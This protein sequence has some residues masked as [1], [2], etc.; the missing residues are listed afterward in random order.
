MFPRSL[1]GSVLQDASFRNQYA[2]KVDAKL[3]FG[4]VQLQRSVLFGAIRKLYDGSATTE[5]TTVDG[6]TATLTLR[7]NPDDNGVDIAID[8]KTIQVPSFWFLSSDSELRR[9]EFAREASTIDF[10]EKSLAF[11]STRFDG[12]ALSDD[13]VLD[14][15]E[16]LKTTPQEVADGIRIELGKPETE[17]STFVPRSLRYYERLLGDLSSTSLAEYESKFAAAHFTHLLN[18]D[19]GL[20]F[21]QFLLVCAHPDIA[22]L[23]SLDGHSPQTVE[24]FFE[25]LA[26]DGSKFSQVGG[27]EIGVRSLERYPQIEGSL[28]QIAKTLQSENVEGKSGRLAL[29]AGL[30]IFV[31]GE[32]SRVGLFRDKPPF[33]RRLASWAQASLIERE[34][35]RAGV[36]LEDAAD[37][38]MNGRGQH[39]FVQT[40]A[41]LRREPRWL[42]DLMTPRQLKFEF[43]SRLFIAADRANAVIPEGELKRLCLSEDEDSIRSGLVMP[44][45]YLPGPLEGGSTSPEVLPE[46]FWNELRAPQDDKV[47]EGNFFAGVVNLAMVFRMDA[48]I[49]N[50][51]ADILR[52]VNYRLSVGADQDLS[53][54]LLSG[55]AVIAAAT[56]TPALAAE[57]RVLARVM[58]R[59]GDLSEEGDAHLRIALM[60]SASSE[61]LED[62]CK[63]VGEWLRE[64]SYEPMT[65]DEAWMLHAHVK[66]LCQVE[67]LLWRYAA[68]SYA[69]LKAV[70]G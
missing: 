69:A 9:T 70:V 16:V 20:G 67:P 47:L 12:P 49:A 40:L 31:D 24:K 13:E 14:Y 56:R 63:A 65:A 1:R 28:L 2:I 22:P 68:P 27:F 3:S 34:M 35:V 11:W 29:C 52:K 58:R 62:W 46:R 44:W 19:F 36:D 61:E 55:L 6:K 26:T 33:L 50:L 39:F 43:L 38:S 10:G 54:S 42:P 41:D 21:S 57:V 5:A 4:P 64:I 51:I 15:L 23:V 32:L 18:W 60:A 59:R 53:F 17:A 45:T 30:F 8:G 25:Q 48:E 7:A 37:W 66:K